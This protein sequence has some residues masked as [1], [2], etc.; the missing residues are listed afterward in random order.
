MKTKNT[1][2]QIDLVIKLLEEK[3]NNIINERI[4]LS[5][6]CFCGKVALGAD[7][8]FDKLSSIFDKIKDTNLALTIGGSIN[9]YG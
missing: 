7:F 6:S 3:V 5:D 8:I 9:V 1:I 4:G 2:D